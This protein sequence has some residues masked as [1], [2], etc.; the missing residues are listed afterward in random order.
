M[1]GDAYPMRV[2]AWPSVMEGFEV[3]ELNDVKDV[4]VTE[5]AIDEPNDS[6]RCISGGDSSEETVRRWLGGVLYVGFAIAEKC[7]GRSLLNEFK[8]SAAV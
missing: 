5:G 7:G 3:S 2:A 1:G 4:W 6:D 8:C